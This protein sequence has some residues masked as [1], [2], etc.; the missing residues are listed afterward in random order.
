LFSSSAVFQGPLVS[1]IGGGDIS[2]YVGL[3]VALL[4]YYLTMRSR[5]TASRGPL[6]TPV[7]SEATPTGVA[8]ADAST[9]EASA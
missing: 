9:G 3:L 2:I 1:S 8:A 6:G 5:V 4:G 7:S